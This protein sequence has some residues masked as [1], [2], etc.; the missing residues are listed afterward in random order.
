MA[1]KSDRQSGKDQRDSDPIGSLSQT[2]VGKVG[3]GAGQYAGLGLQFVVAILAFL[4]LGNWIDGR[5][6]TGPLFLILGVFV[7]AGTAFYSIYRKVM[8]EPKSADRRTRDREGK[9]N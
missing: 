5:L 3:G 4:Y 2:G 8:A 7:G 6:G 1:E 9:G